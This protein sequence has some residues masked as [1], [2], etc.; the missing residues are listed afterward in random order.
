MKLTIIIKSKGII[1]DKI[2]RID[3][4]L[5]VNGDTNSDRYYYCTEEILKSYCKEKNL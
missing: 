5:R 3:K 4:N 1:V 2:K